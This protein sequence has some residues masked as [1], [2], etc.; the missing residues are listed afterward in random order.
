MV[1][2]EGLQIAIADGLFVAGHVGK[3]DE[4][5]VGV[6]VA[7]RS[8]MDSSAHVQGSRTHGAVAAEAEG[9][10]GLDQ[11]DVVCYE[12]HDHQRGKA[13]PDENFA[14]NMGVDG[15]VYGGQEPRHAGMGFA[16]STVGLMR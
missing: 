16:G 3:T 9:L 14:E 8:T 6:A 10:G 15:A 4:E 2:V 11:S 13:L 12:L 5:E 1:V 7:G